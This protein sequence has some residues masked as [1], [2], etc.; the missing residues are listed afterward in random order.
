MK[1]WHKIFGN[2]APIHIDYTH[3]SHTVHNYIPNDFIQK[4]SRELDLIVYGATGFT[5]SIICKYLSK[6]YG[7]NK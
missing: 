4:D 7:L 5:G 1:I 6:N 2:K 3:E